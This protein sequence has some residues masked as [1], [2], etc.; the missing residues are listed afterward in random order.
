MPAEGFLSAERG[1]LVCRRKKGGFSCR[2]GKQRRR[3]DLNV[4]ARVS[5]R[6]DDYERKEG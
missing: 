5:L 1:N 6:H 4:N 2:A 3:W